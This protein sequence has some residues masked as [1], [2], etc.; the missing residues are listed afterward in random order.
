[1]RLLTLLSCA[2]LLMIFSVAAHSEGAKGDAAKGEA[3]PQRVLCFGDSI[4]QGGA[5]PVAE[6]TSLW[7]LQVEKKADGKLR[8]LNE[9]KGGRPTNSVEEFR[10]A[11]KK[12]DGAFDELLISLG[13]NDSRDITDKCVPEAV[14]NIR[15]M[16]TM[17]REKVP[18]LRV[19]LVGPPNINKNA[20]GPTKPIANEREQ[21]LKDLNAAFEQLAKDEKCDFVSLF[22]AVPDESLLRDG[23]HPDAKGNTAIAAVIYGALLPDA[24]R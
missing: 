16:I 2:L 7:L 13:T 24:R 21:K 3:G 5:L 8:L 10:A 11:L 1:M 22:G 14:K 12:H 19:L 4:T 18:N 17:A 15:Q 6:K 20:L 23:V 9:G